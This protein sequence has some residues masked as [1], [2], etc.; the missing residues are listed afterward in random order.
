MSSQEAT[1]D[2]VQSMRDQ[3]I[4]DACAGREPLCWIVTDS[5]CDI[6][7]R[8]GSDDVPQMLIPDDGEK[9]REAFAYARAYGANR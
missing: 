4:A 2:N 1:D 5:G 9:Y 8:R 7:L 3:G 6:L